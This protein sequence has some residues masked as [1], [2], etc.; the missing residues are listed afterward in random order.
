MS[1]ENARTSFSTSEM[2]EIRGLIQELMSANSSRQR[3]IRAKLRSQGLY[4]DEVGN[5]MPY[6]LESLGI[7]ISNGIIKITDSPADLNK[8]ITI[9]RSPQTSNNMTNKGRE[10][11]DEHYVI[12]LCD[13][14]L[15]QHAARQHKFDF[16]KGDGDK[17][18]CLPVDAYYE[19]LNLVIEYHECQHSEEVKLFDKRDTV[20]GVSRGEQRKIY[21]KR[22]EE[23]LPEHDIKLI[24]ID[25]KD[26]GD[27]KN[28]KLQRNH[29]KDIKIVEEILTNH[30]IPVKTDS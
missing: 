16:L 22:R 27:S 21:D 18:R 24:V 12:N 29:D 4:W 25:Y 26:F 6:T 30:G 13:E 15:G 9:Q 3:S 10:N 17:P 2:A 11:S 8:E 19:N 20:S 28:K 7:L 5:R 1:R 23:T 14:V